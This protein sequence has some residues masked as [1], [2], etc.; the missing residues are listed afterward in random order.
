MATGQTTTRT[1][2][3]AHSPAVKTCDLCGEHRFDLVSERDRHGEVLHTAMC[4]NCGLVS[5]LEIPSE[6]QLA[7]FYA[8]EYRQSYHGE[9]APSARRVMRAWNNG[10]RILKQLQDAVPP[11]ASVFEVGAG[12]GCTVKSFELAGYQAEGIDPGEGFIDYSRQRLGAKVSVGNLFDIDPR[13]QY[14]LVL[15]VHVIEHFSSPRRALSHIRQM[16]RPGGRLYVECPNLTAPLAPFSKMFHFA[17]VHNFN[18]CTLRMMAG[19]TGF[20]VEHVFSSSDDPNLQVLFQRSDDPP[21]AIERANV[22]STSTALQRAKSW[23]GYHTRAAYMGRRLRKLA[24]YANEH[25]RAKS[26]VRRLE[27]RCQ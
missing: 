25:L 5:H 15:L 11:P 18:E 8:R 14:D 2:R 19:Q 6:A 10:Q 4:L 3:S 13:P 26:V 23:L 22:I 9:T 24:S 7:E 17:H 12:I 21:S 20:R 16:I 1:T 27:N